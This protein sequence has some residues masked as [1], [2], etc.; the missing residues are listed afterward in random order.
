MEANNYY[1]DQEVVE[2]ILTLDSFR[3]QEQKDHNVWQEV[4]MRQSDESDK[5]KRQEQL[6]IVDLRWRINRK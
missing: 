1:E 5:H 4:W 6:G 3:K 2:D